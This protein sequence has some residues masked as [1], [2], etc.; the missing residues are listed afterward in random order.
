MFIDKASNKIVQYNYEKLKRN[1]FCR[2]FLHFIAFFLV[3]YAV[4]LVYCVQ[5]PLYFAPVPLEILIFY[6]ITYTI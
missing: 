6:S 3:F 5:F 4:V 1:E 2:K